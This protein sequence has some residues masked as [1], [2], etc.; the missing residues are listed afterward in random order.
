L[1]ALC[2]RATHQETRCAA[3]LIER[4]HKEMSG[5]REWLQAQPQERSSAKG[6]ERLW[7]RGDNASAEIAT[8]KPHPPL[9]W[10]GGGGR[11]DA[12]RR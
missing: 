4:L 10:S 11:G 3:R 9:H 5:L 6:E 12:E 2:W 7:G 8:G 1:P